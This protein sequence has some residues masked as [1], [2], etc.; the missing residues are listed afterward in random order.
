MGKAQMVVNSRVQAG[1]VTGTVRMNRVAPA[2][3]PTTTTV[4][5]PGPMALRRSDSVERSNVEAGTAFAAAELPTT[6]TVLV[7]GPR[8]LR[9]SKSFEEAGCALRRTGSDSS[10]ISV[11]R[12]LSPASAHHEPDALNRQEEPRP[13]DA[14]EEYVWSSCAPNAYG[15]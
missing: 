14:E 3:L 2:E 4:P 12:P 8:A 15:M 7:P 5:V 11:K 6:P 9:R 1:A 10:A 13:G